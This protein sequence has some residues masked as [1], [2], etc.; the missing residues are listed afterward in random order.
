VTVLDDPDEVCRLAAQAAH[1][2]GRLDRRH[3]Q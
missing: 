1:R 2:Q 3:G